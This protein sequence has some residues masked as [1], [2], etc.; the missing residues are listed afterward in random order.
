MFGLT[1]A[2]L[3][4]DSEEFPIVEF[5]EKVVQ[6]ID[7]ELYFGVL[8]KYDMGNNHGL[9][10]PVEKTILIRE[11]VYENALRGNGRDRFTIAHELAHYLMHTRQD[12][13]FY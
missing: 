1:Y 9:T 2:K 8:T 5:I 10:D 3:Y 12:I 13:V 11:D 6:K 4:D 7:K